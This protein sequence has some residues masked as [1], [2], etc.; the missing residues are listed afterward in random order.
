MAR[1]YVEWP[2]TPAVAAELERAQEGIRDD[3]THRATLVVHFAVRDAD[4]SDDEWYV[5][6]DSTLS[7]PGYE[8]S[9]PLTAVDGPDTL[10][11]LADELLTA[12]KRQRARLLE[13]AW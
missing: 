13:V 2:S 9:V 4:A 6:L 8:A 7:M 12:C 3:R 11:A 1:N 5:Y 10:D